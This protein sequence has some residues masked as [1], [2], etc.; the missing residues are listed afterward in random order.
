MDLR[1]RRQGVVRGTAT[2]ATGGPREPVLELD[3]VPLQADV[4]VGD[5]IVTAGIDGI[6]PRGIPIGT[7]AR[8]ERGGQLFYRILIAP[9]VDFAALDQVFLLDHEQVPGQVKEAVPRPPGPPGPQ[10]ADR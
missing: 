1:T 6:Y 9:A 5:R 8:V 3:Y 2:I 10:N 7:V 4:R